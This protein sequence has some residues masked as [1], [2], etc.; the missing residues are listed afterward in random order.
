MPE[1]TKDGFEKFISAKKVVNNVLDELSSF[2][3]ANIIPT[4]QLYRYIKRGLDEL[5][6]FV[7]KEHSAVL[8]VE[9]HKATLPENFKKLYSAYMCSPVSNSPRRVYPQSSFVWY[10]DSTYENFLEN[11]CCPDGDRCFDE[12]SRLTIRH[13]YEMQPIDITFHQPRVLRLVPSRGLDI[14]TDDCPNL[15]YHCS[16]E[17]SITYNE[18][19]DQ[20]T[21]NTNF[22]CG[23]VYIQY[24]G[25]P[26]ADGL[27]MVPDDSFVVDY[28]EK[29]ILFKILRNWWYNKEVEDI[30]RR[31]LFA[32]EEHRVSFAKVKYYAKLPSFSS[33]IDYA[34]QQRKTRFAK[35][36]YLKD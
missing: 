33:M 2:A 1:I 34:R 12:K 23:Y 29:L 13:Y 15:G 3:D 27:P 17:I 8:E 35:F 22:D 14:C 11:N 7:Y 25:T 9:K 24:Y 18:G 19:N 20:Y 5:G 30:E 32:K 4:H 10:S 21:L 6:F 28:L 36:Q 26:V 16:D 31:M